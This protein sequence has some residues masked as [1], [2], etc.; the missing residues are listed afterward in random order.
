MPLVLK[1]EAYYSITRL[2]KLWETIALNWD[3]INPADIARQAR[4]KKGEV[5]AQLSELEK[6]FIIQRAA[7]DTQTHL[8]YLNRTLF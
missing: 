4:L 1:E 8:Y 3:A 2:F 5:S 6:V 7:T